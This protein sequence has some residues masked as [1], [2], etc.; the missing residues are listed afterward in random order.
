MAETEPA[1]EVVRTDP[2]EDPAPVARTELV[3]QFQPSDL[4]L[5]ERLLYEPL[6]EHLAAVDGAL[7]LTG[8]FTQIVEPGE[9]IMIREFY[10]RVG[11][12]SEKLNELKNPTR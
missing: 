12:F 7:V 10:R 11:T 2:S 4:E 5:G 6:R 1:F 3:P 9:E 8:P